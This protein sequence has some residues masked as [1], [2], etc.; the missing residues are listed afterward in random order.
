MSQICKKIEDGSEMDL[1]DD[2]PAEV[3]L[4]FFLLLRF[5]VCISKCSVGTKKET[6]VGVA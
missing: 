2:K 3:K 5:I 1:D 4:S 6:N